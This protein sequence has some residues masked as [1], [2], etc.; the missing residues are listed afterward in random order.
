MIT[1]NNEFIKEKLKD[2]M[3]IDW[4]KFCNFNFINFKLS[5]V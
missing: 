1:A 4:F 3:Y 2:V 5:D